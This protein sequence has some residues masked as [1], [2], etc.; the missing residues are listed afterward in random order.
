MAIK[1]I[2]LFLLLAAPFPGAVLRA[3]PEPS[4]QN[5][6]AAE[7]S[8]IKDRL[9]TS[10]FFR[11]ELA[12]KILAAGIAGRF[13][14]LAGLETNAGA[15]GALLE[16]IR[17]NPAKA[18]EVYLNMKGAGGQLH[19]RIETREMEWKFN[20]DFLDMIK[21]LN[22]A[23]GSASVSREALELAA[24]RLYE[25]RQEGTGGPEV[26]PGSPGSGGNNFFS[27]D[28]AAYRLNK[29]GLEREVAQ[30]GAWLESARGVGPRLEIEGAYSAAFSLYREFIV[31]ASALKGREAV[32]ESESR[33][34]EELRFKLR[35]SLA[36]LALR[37]RISAL[38][39]AEASLKKLGAEPG[40]AELLPPVSRLREELAASA[41]GIEA[42]G[43][44]LAGLGRAV[45]S[46]ENEFAPLY[47]RYS[48]YDGLLNLKRRASGHGFSCL[49]DYAVYRY[50]AAFFPGSAYPAARAELAAAAGALD[51]ALLKAGAGDLSGALSGLGTGRVE[52]AAATVRSA[53]SFNRGAQFFLWGLLFRP[54]E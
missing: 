21:A 8:S 36:A 45:N 50:L 43:V 49:Y 28:Y 11:G 40:A 4:P 42:G 6:Q 51:A 54:V 41:A 38:S 53:S 22:A 10:L 30:A 2:L 7:L 44:A 29:S 46:A 19:D 3:E 37:S 34:L 5:A 17:K 35:S 52:A 12:D 27:I 39:E 9:L 23:A 16:W 13:V 14:D 15:K 1:P 33:R 24:R 31:A 25:G 32:T 48:A 26:R 18:A 20:P 47:L